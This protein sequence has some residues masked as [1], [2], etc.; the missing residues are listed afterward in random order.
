MGNTGGTDYRNND[1]AIFDPTI[2][3]ACANNV[4]RNNSI[5]FDT[6]TTQT[7]TV[8]KVL[9]VVGAFNNAF[10]DNEYSPSAYAINPTYVTKYDFP[11]TKPR[12][13]GVER[14][15][16]IAG[17]DDTAYSYGQVVVTAVGAS[18]GHTS[19][20]SQIKLTGLYNPNISNLFTFDDATWTFTAPYSGQLRIT[21]NNIYRPDAGAVNQVAKIYVYKNG[22]AYHTQSIPQGFQVSATDQNYT[23]DVVMSVSLGDD[24]TL[25]AEVAAGTLTSISSTTSTTTF[26]ML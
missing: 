3:S 14:G 22:V 6:P 9:D 15:I 20:P 19:T 13:Y 24:I 12:M 16:Q 2:S 8:F 21:S 25:F 26:Q 4:I 11:T 10:I 17:S 5:R 18:V 7:I 23:F 1:I